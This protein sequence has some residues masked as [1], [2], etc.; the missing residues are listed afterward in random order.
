MTFLRLAPERLLNFFGSGRFAHFEHFMGVQ[1]H[2]RAVRIVGGIAGIVALGQKVESGC[3]R[4]WRPEKR[5]GVLTW[6]SATTGRE[7]RDPG[8]NK[9]PAHLSTKTNVLEACLGVQK[10]ILSLLSSA[11]PVKRAS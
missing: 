9:T 4:T 6:N 3:S 5:G 11:V 1:I 2:V 7:S 8:P 10:P